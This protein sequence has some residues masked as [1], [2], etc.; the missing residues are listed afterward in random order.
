M[1]REPKTWG[2]EI[3]VHQGTVMPGLSLHK[4]HNFSFLLN[5]LFSTLNC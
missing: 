5:D 2:T 3:V 4:I 1:K